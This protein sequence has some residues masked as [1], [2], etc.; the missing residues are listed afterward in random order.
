MRNNKGNFTT[1]GVV[2]ISDVIAFVI[3]ILL[4]DLGLERFKDFNI[5][6]WFEDVRAN[7]Y[8]NKYQ[9]DFSYYNEPCLRYFIMTP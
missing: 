7:V 4:I 6:F 5:T 2:P 8:S 3:N 1:P 9:F